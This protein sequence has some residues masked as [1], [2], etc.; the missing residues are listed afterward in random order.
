[1]DYTILDTPATLCRRG[2]IRRRRTTHTSRSPVLPALPV[3]P[4]PPPPSA[5]PPWPGDVPPRPSLWQRALTWFRRRSVPTYDALS[6]G[7]ASP[8]SLE[9]PF[10]LPSLRRP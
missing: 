8:D 2:A 5:P 7:S 4:P 10:E 9:A 3:T 1:M 6:S